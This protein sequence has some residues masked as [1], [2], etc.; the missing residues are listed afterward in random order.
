MNNKLQITQL[1]N[2]LTFHNVE[3][4]TKIKIIS[5][6][7]DISRST[8]FKCLKNNK[9]D[10]DNYNNNFIK[11]HKYKNKN[12]T[13]AVEN[14]IINNI[15][16]YN[17]IVKLKKYINI[18]LNTNISNNIIKCV[19]ACNNLKIKNVNI[20]INDLVKINCPSNNI[21]PFITDDIE[22]FI[23]D[24][25]HNS[26]KLVVND[27]YDK[28]N[29]KCSKKDIIGIYQ[30]HKI[31]KQ[32]FYKITP[33]IDNYVFNKITNNKIL[34]ANDIINDLY[35]EYKIKIST[36]SIY[37][38][39]KK[40]N[41]SYKKIKFNNNPHSLEDQKER[42]KQV[43]D[44][45][46][47]ININNMLTYDEISIVLNSKPDNGWS[48]I[49]EE[50]VV[51]KNDSKIYS[52]RYTVGMIASN[53][54]IID[55]CVV[56]KGLKTNDYINFM[57]KVYNN[58]DNKENM[59][60]FLDNASIHTCNSSKDLYKKNN[61]HIIFNAPY[62][63]E[64]NPIEYIFSMLRNEINRNQNNTINEIEKTINK[65]MTE[66]KEESISNIYNNCIKKIK[67][68]IE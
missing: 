21:T 17:S 41:L 7:Y 27:I 38:I 33:F 48:L 32:S 43:N 23:I 67:T 24:N 65:F 9:N 36:T 44:S 14:L 39:Y 8:I 50:C 29:V 13:Y 11:L 16:K 22:K 64:F 49:N 55:Y 34:T 54:K 42:I 59:S 1:Y 35:N 46:E 18:T 30:K 47:S 53:K 57:D 40:H 66:I 3:S 26:I 10:N 4:K 60:I 62:H 6:T 28:F 31:N 37:N 61:M 52:T 58:L 25:Q 68:F 51:D 5:N 63:S 15:D 2:S 56:S 12:I 45:I 19:M 20:N